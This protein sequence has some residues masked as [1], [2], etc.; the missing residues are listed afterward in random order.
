VPERAIAVVQARTG[1]AK[2]AAYNVVGIA[3][4]KLRKTAP[5]S[6][7]GR[8]LWDLHSS[9]MS[10]ARSLATSGRPP[11]PRHQKSRR[12]PGSP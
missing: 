9:D 10:Y 12:G 3:I 5:L 1:V 6:E 8:L 2:S 11:G 7:T 4:A